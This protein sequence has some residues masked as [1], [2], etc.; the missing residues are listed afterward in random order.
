MLSKEKQNKIVNDIAE[1]AKWSLRNLILVSPRAFSY[2]ELL[3]RIG[4]QLI[5][6]AEKERK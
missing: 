6:E 5:A 2:S 3:K 1:G 4:E